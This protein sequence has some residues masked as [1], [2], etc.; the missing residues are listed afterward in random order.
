MIREHL[1]FVPAVADFVRKGYS[2]SKMSEGIRV[3]KKIMDVKISN[4]RKEAF[5]HAERIESLLKQVIH[6]MEA[7]AQCGTYESDSHEADGTITFLF[8]DVSFLKRLRQHRLPLPVS[9]RTEDHSCQSISE[10][11]S[12]TLPPQEW[13]IQIGNIREGTI[14]RFCISRLIGAI[15]ETSIHEYET[16]VAPMDTQN[17]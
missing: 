2:L 12:C 6:E 9:A 13:D 8:Q 5:V 16:S 7:L 10:R 15:Q 14:Y 3:D 1:L 11:S 17:E 4:C